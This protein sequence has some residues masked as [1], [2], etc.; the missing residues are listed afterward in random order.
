MARWNNYDYKPTFN[1][2]GMQGWG[3]F[4]RY[5]HGVHKLGYGA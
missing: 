4:C 2:F 1:Y 3:D 5:N